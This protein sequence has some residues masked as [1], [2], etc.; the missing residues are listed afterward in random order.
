MN[1]LRLLARQDFFE[2]FPGRKTPEHQKVKDIENCGL[3]FPRIGESGTIDDTGMEWEFRCPIL[4]ENLKD[5]LID[6]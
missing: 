4:W 5:A 2:D 3:A 1:S 6:G